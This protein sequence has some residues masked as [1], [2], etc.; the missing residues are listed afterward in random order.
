MV[1]G[2]RGHKTMK[3]NFTLAF[4]NGTRTCDKVTLFKVQKRAVLKNAFEVEIA[5]YNY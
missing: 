1:G 3:V 2:H 4:V 5:K